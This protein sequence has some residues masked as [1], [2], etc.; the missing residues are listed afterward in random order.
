MSSKSNDM[1]ERQ[2]ALWMLDTMGESQEFLEV[3]RRA[4]RRGRRDVLDTADYVAE[5]TGKAKRLYQG[6]DEEETDVSTSVA[7]LVE[8]AVDRDVLSSREEL[9]E[10]AIAAYLDT[11]PDGAAG[12]P[13]GWQTTIEMARAEI[14]G[15]TSGAF[16]A[17]FVADLA[18]AARDEMAREQNAAR[19]RDHDRGGRE[20]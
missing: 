12:L 8:A 13:E 2:L 16:H 18:A 17:G 7:G 6:T 4:R 10:K 1:D 19:A 14:E 20:E 3:L 5:H 15:R 9:I 11:H